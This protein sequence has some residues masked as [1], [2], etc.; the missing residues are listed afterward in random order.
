M[1]AFRGKSPPSLLGGGGRRIYLRQYVAAPPTADF[2]TAAAS[3]SAEIVLDLCMTILYT[4]DYKKGIIMKIKDMIVFH[5]EKII[6]DGEVI[7]LDQ[8]NTFWNI[9]LW[10]EEKYPNIPIEIVNEGMGER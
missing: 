1:S 4:W 8:N 3:P 9:R 6:D 5:K 7:L 2:V 10:I